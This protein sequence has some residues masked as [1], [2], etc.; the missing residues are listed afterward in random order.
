M[1]R[2]ILSIIVST[3]MIGKARAKVKMLANHETYPTNEYPYENK[4]EFSQE[5]NNDTVV[6]QNEEDIVIDQTPVEEKRKPSVDMENIYSLSKLDGESDIETLERIKNALDSMD[7]NLKDSLGRY[8][9][10]C[11]K[12]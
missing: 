10:K 8:L 9:L 5:L 3:V 2:K 11:I 6:D 1:K 4:D 12:Q 7:E